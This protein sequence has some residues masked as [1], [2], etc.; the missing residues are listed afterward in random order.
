M[1]DEHYKI[2]SARLSDEVIQELQNRRKIHK[3]WNLL[4][5]SLLGFKKE[6]KWKTKKK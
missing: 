3:S 1:R 5:R 2:F 4:F 6:F